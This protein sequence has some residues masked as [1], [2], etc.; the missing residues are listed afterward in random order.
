[1]EWSSEDEDYVYGED[2]DTSEEEDSGSDN[3][4][5]EN[6]EEINEV[7]SC[8]ICFEVM[9]CPGICCRSSWCLWQ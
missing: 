8:P 6:N 1:M 3:H 4:S 9:I 7:F 2:V 5:D